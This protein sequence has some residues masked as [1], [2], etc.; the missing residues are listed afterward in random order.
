MQY[1]SFFCFVDQVEFQVFNRWGQV[2]FETNDPHLNWNGTNLK[3]EDLAEGTYYYTCLVYE[4][5]VEGTIL[6][7]VKLSG[8]IELIR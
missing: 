4:Q 7:S 3:G 5:R 2:V 1:R 6:S 8:F